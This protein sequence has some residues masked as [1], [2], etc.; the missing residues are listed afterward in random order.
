M[1]GQTYSDQSESSTGLQSPI[2]WQ[3]GSPGFSKT[4]CNFLNEN[5]EEVVPGSRGDFRQIQ[6]FLSAQAEQLPA[7]L[8]GPILI[9]V[10]IRKPEA[11]GNVSENQH[12]YVNFS[13]REKF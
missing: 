13:Y 4:Q 6:E 9:N 1:S 8:W 3:R 10:P 7:I 5:W 11:S 2:F 12:Q